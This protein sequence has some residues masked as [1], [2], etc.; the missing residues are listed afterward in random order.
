MPEDGRREG[1]LYEERKES[2]GKVRLR[3]KAEK[4]QTASLD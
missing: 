3:R 4:K 2:K 1:I